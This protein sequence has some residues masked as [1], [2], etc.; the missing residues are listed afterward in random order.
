MTTQKGCEFIMPSFK[1]EKGPFY[2]LK[3]CDGNCI[4]P[5]I[6][7]R[8]STQRDFKV[9]LACIIVLLIGA[10]RTAMW[11]LYICR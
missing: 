8:K 9:L 4:V 3:R 2:V 6:A 5:Q 7:L 10:L 1:I 11:L